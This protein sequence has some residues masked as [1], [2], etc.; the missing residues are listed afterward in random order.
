MG[1]LFLPVG[2]DAADRAVIQAYADSHEIGYLDA[3]DLAKK[4]GVG[5]LRIMVAKNELSQRIASGRVRLRPVGG[6]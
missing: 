6:A 5:R 1:K 4:F 2:Y 3:L